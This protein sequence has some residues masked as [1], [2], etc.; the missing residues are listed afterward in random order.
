MY[1]HRDHG[2]LIFTLSV[3]FELIVILTQTIPSDT[4]IAID[5]STL[6]IT[7]YNYCCPR[8][9]LVYFVTLLSN[10]IIYTAS[11]RI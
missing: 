11:I 4:A 1:D 10:N 3:T 2:D 5:I 7:N 6:N 9:I 8:E